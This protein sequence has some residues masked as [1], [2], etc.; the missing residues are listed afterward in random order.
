MA[1]RAFSIRLILVYVALFLTIG[2]YLP[3]FPVWLKERGLSETEIAFLLSGTIAIRIIS[4]PLIAFLADKSGQHRRILL[5]LC[6]GVAGFVVA[7]AFSSGF[8][9]L[10]ALS[11]AGTFIWAPVMPMIETY[12]VRE[13]GLYGVDYGRLR[14]WG[15]LSFIAAGL[16]GGLLLDFISAEAIITTLVATHLLMFFACRMLPPERAEA[17]SE[18][19]AITPGGLRLSHAVRL[20]TH[21]LF[22]VFL[23]AAGLGQASHAVIYGFGSLHWRELG[24]PGG[25][26]GILWGAGVAAE[27]LLFAYSGQ[28]LKRFGAAGLIL[29]AA[30]AGIVRW[31][32]TANDP[33]FALLFAI[34]MLH[35]L[36]FA[37][38]HLGALHFINQAIPRALQ[39]TAQGVYYAFGVSLLM[40]IATIVAGDIY[41]THGAYA[42]YCASAMS[43]VAAVFAWRLQAQ[44]CGGRI[45]TTPTGPPV[46]DASQSRQT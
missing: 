35:A 6:L 23:L 44:W 34:Q 37:A 1:A 25:T 26:I 29:V 38:A 32:I 18:E 3:F 19:E 20:L 15:S 41:S 22:L 36:T 27:V 10:L 43:A 45:T 5:A 8:L 42:F 24:L 40:S 17:D 12:A 13:S 31:S 4:G 21:P 33:A 30:L 11:V 2:I 39:A 16:A 14:L 9:A 28:S 7:M 46:L